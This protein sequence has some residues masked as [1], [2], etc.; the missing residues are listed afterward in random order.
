M[1]KNNREGIPKILRNKDASDVD[2]PR[3]P[4]NDLD[5]GKISGERQAEGEGNRGLSNDVESALLP[6]N[7]TDLGK[8]NVG[9][10]GG[11]E[12]SFDGDRFS[13]FRLLPDFPDGGEGENGKWEEERVKERGSD[14]VKSGSGGDRNPSPSPSPTKPTS[15]FPPTPTVNDPES[16]GGQRARDGLRESLQYTKGLQYLVGTG[17][18]KENRRKVWLYGDHF[19][20]NPYNEN[21]N[22]PDYIRR[23]RNVYKYKPQRKGFL[24]DGEQKASPLLSKLGMFEDQD[25]LIR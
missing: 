2:E 23:S 13:P 20:F 12:G 10:E 17:I 14:K 3:P 9:R 18:P 8:W 22:H 21:Q 25:Q 4:L 15:P 11:G 5:K 1:S 19:D 16:N 6:F 24:S 7:D